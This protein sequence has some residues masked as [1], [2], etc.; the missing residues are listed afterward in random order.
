MWDWEL[1]DI[2]IHFVALE[3]VQDERHYIRQ[4]RPQMCMLLILVPAC[5]VITD[6][7][8]TTGLEKSYPN[9]WHWIWRSASWDF[10]RLVYL[11]YIVSI[12]AHDW[13]S[14]AVGKPVAEAVGTV[15]VADIVGTV[16]AEVVG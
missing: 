4:L 2:Q 1:E 9:I 13:V 15:L 6:L 7:D 10:L 14:E 5:P 12:K 3:Y 16:A 8:K 11:I